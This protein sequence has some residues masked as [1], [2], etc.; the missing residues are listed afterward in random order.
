MLQFYTFL[1][2]KTLL[3]SQNN[4]SDTRVWVSCLSSNSL[5]HQLCVLQS[6]Q[7]WHCLPGVSIRPH[8]WR[9]QSHETTPTLQVSG[10][11][12]CFW[13]ISHKP[14]FLGPLL[15]FSNLL[16]LLTELRETLM[17]SSLLKDVIK[18]TDEQLDEELHR[19]RS[20]SNPSTGASVPLKLGCI[21]LPFHGCVLQPGSLP[22][23]ILLG[24]LWRLH[25]IGRMVS[26]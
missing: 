1:K 12:L 13:T 25:H 7:S 16:K 4:P 8:R 15:G 24:V 17:F 10:Y 19:E 20:R 14:G 3:H 6:F 23:P 18:D 9:A 22:D 2:L 21:T 26:H 11:H 5:W